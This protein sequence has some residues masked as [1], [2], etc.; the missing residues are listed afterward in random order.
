MKSRLLH[1]LIWHVVAVFIPFVFH[2]T[3]TMMEAGLKAETTGTWLSEDLETSESKTPASTS[4]LRT[5]HAWL[6]EAQFANK[7]SIKSAGQDS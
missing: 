4:S 1:P 3:A 5:L 7:N 2:K 6:K